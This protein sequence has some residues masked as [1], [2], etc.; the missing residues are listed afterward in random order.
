MLVIE[1]VS[2]YV[3]YVSNHV[4]SI[5]SDLFA[6]EMKANAEALILRSLMP[7]MQ[8]NPAFIKF[9]RRMTRRAKYYVT[10]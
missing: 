2:R 4:K 9:Y 10:E 1:A 3:V 6:A 8:G 5:R 7:R